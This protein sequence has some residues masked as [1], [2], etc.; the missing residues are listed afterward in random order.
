MV[1]NCT[2]VARKNLDK[3]HHGL[4]DVAEDRVQHICLLLVLLEELGDTKVELVC[5]IRSLDLRL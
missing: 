2:R 1:I 4:Y 5:I 3:L